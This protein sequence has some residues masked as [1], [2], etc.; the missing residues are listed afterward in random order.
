[1][2][3]F[4]ELEVGEKLWCVRLSGKMVEYI[5]DRIDIKDGVITFALK[6]HT[7][8]ISLNIREEATKSFVKLG[9]AYFGTE[10]KDT[11]DKVYQQMSED[12]DKLI[13]NTIST[14][15]ERFNR[16]DKSYENI[17]RT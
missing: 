14:F 2:K 5:I 1:M 15:F 3:T 17:Q 7:Y 11:Y 4:Q 6:S 16:L 9:G 13:S 10:L 12:C 8:V